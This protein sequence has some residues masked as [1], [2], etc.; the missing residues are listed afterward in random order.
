MR[1]RNIGIAGKTL[2]GITVLVAIGLGAIVTGTVAVMRIERTLNEITAIAA[3]TV[4]AAGAVTQ[5]VGAAHR[6]ALAVT[7]TERTADAQALTGNYEAAA[8]RYGDAIDTLE[9]VAVDPQ[10]QP[11]ISR[12]R[13]EWTEFDAQVQAMFA[14]HQ[15]RLAA[16]A[17]ARSLM[18]EFEA[19]GAL[20]TDRL[21]DIAADKA[22]KMQEAEE[23]AGTLAELPFTTAQMLYTLIDTVFGQDYP[24]YAAA[25]ELQKIV[26]TLEGV[27]REYMAITDPAELP[28]IRAEFV[29]AF[30]AADPHFETLLALTKAPS[31]R[32]AF[33]A[34][35]ADLTAWVTRAKADGQLFDRHRAMLDARESAGMIAGELAAA[36]QSLTGTVDAVAQAADGFSQ[37]ADGLA[38]Q[39][40]QAAQWI[41]GAM[42]LAM[43]AAGAAIAWASAKWIS[44]P[45]RKLTETM[46][47][48]SNGHL[49]TQLERSERTHEIGKM[50]NAMV[51]FLA[52]EKER[53]EQQTR[54][55]A[56]TA[57]TAAVV[58]GLSQA[59]ADLSNGDLTA[60]MSMTVGA[61]FE[62]LCNNY[63]RS[64]ERLNAILSDVVKTS[65]DISQGMDSVAQASEQLSFRTEKQASALAET[66]STIA[67]IKTEV[68]ETA[69]GAKNAR[70][71]AQSAREKA[72]SGRSVVTQTVSAMDRIKK[73]SEE[74]AQITTAIDDIAF[75]T[76][77]LALNAGVEAARAGEAGRGFAV[78]AAEVRGLAQRA[79]TAARDIKTLIDSS[80]TEVA[81][82]ARI[83]GDTRTALREIADT[84]GVVNDA[85]EAIAQSAQAQAHSVQQ[86]NVAM[87]E[88]ESL[89]QQ[90][91]AM[92]EETTAATLELQGEATAMRQNASRFTLDKGYP[93]VTSATGDRAA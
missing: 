21:A 56:R 78:V 14:A 12:T 90:N 68:E 80:Q 15:D 75:Q 29:E 18:A 31:E 72:E 71:L 64:A 66:S 74:I 8:T 9:Q 57:E 85:V 3:P 24:A 88:L 4:K 46:E 20:L 50:T 65:V 34:L 51:V 87:A 30:A 19:D 93:P 44:R 59:L 40:V 84:V 36:A 82:G 79:S 58:D 37:R 83:A 25:V 53:R 81:D 41:L 49:E 45:L 6:T 13:S 2:L 16:R 91:A 60:R 33:E 38:A 70:E 43:L 42:L 26:A 52:G 5:E 55:T 11:L 27:A 77:L 76:N 22:R 1:I 7:A 17:D 62:P 63:N 86:I 32:A 28:G 23:S 67:Q 10:M 47:A 69:S 92:V 89:T 48:V 73:S 54:E 35:I 39:K 61:E